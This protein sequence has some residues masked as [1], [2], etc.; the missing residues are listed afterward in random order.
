MLRRGFNREGTMKISKRLAA[1]LAA[2]AAALCVSAGTASAQ[3]R[4]AAMDTSGPV[5]WGASMEDARKQAVAA[6]KKSSRK[7]S[8]AAAA[9]SDMSFQFYEVCC[10][11]PSVKC[12]VAGRATRQ[13]ALEALDPVFKSAGLSNCT[14]RRIVS[15][16]TGKPV[17]E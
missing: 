1:V 17:K 7:C 10:T 5:A 6:C 2:A 13:E 11:K 4:W 16:S 9:T 15:A 14:P 3:Q 8:G 12:A